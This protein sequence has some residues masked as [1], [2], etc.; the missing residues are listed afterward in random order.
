MPVE[1]VLPVMEFNNVLVIQVESAATAAVL[2]GL[3]TVMLT[4]LKLEQAPELIVHLKR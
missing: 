3:D 4:S 1:G 2:A